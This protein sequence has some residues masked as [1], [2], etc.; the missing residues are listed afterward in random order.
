M[1]LVTGATGQIGGLVARRL[2]ADG[3][4]YR[5]LV[6]D[7]LRAAWLRSAPGVELAVADARRGGLPAVMDG[8]EVLVL[9]PPYE[10]YMH[11]FE[12]RMVTAARTAGVRRVVRLSAIGVDLEDP[13]DTLRLHAQGEQLLERSGHGFTHVRA[14]AF[15]QN[16]IG[17]LPLLLHRSVLPGFNGHAPVASVDARDV[18]EA[19][20]VCAVDA[21]HD[22]ATYEL[23]GPE[24]LTWPDVA[25]ALSAVLG[26]PVP[27]EE[28]PPAQLRRLLVG[29]RW[30]QFPVSE[31]ISI[32]EG[33]FYADGHGGQVTDH[34][35]RLTGRPA[36]SFADYAT[37]L[38]PRAR[39]R[40]A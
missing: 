16:L 23:T 38:L 12:Q 28:V 7:R 40:A 19:M 33:A 6:R 26:R 24:A 22:R 37:G 10:T 14:N 3:V 8:V 5:A 15:H 4:P 36:R 35:E 1:I 21:A 2:T 27:Y 25:E 11:E 18:A 32:F 31:W 20:A 34:V 30:E 13:S 9:V 39:S 17:F 29:Q